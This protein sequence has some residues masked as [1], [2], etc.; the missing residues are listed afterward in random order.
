M[1]EPAGRLA[2][3]DAVRVR[4]DDPPLHT[5]AP[6]YVRGHTGR[7]VAVHPAR[8]VP[9]EVVAGVPAPAREAVYTVW[10][11]AAELWG[12]GTHSVAV[13]LW[14]RYLDPTGGS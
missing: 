8:T 14:E 4:L 13:D 6:R 10:F 9:D 11:A 3:G 2:V 7:V 1:A 5:R 12:D